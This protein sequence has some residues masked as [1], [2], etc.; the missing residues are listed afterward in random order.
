[1]RKA[2][3]PSIAIIDSGAHAGHPHVG[4]I[5]GGFTFQCDASG[6]VKRIEGA[7]DEIGH[8]TAIAGLIRGYAPDT[9]IWALKIFGRHLSAGIP[10]LIAAME[11]ALEIPVEIIHLSLGTAEER[12][13][14]LLENLCET[15][16]R[17]NILVVA[18]ARTRADLV[19]PA[20]F[21]SV[22]GV[23]QDAECPPEGLFHH[24]GMPIAFSAHGMPRPIPGLPQERNFRGGS[25]AA[26]HVSGRILRMRAAEPCMTSDDV[27]NNLIR[28]AITR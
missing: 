3:M 16:R 23:C 19:Y 11:W 2:G 26:A 12:H 28:Q 15:A 21:E 4:Y 18:S 17:R 25:F 1:M 9:G 27:V 10:A 20:V 24:P 7:A 14:P 6:A 5:A 13:K 8:G 22:I